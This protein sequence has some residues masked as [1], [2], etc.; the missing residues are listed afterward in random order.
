MNHAVGMLST[1][2]Q[3][4]FVSKRTSVAMED[5]QEVVTTG[6]VE[7]PAYFVAVDHASRSIV[8]SVRGTFSLSDTMVDLLCNPVGELLRGH[9]TVVYN[10]F[11]AFVLANALMICVY[12]RLLFTCLVL[13]PCVREV[14][15]IHSSADSAPPA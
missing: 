4:W 14:G 11:C 6:S 5:V 12:S 1:Y 10:S 8:L 3:K 7:T 9:I 13:C 2:L 15:T